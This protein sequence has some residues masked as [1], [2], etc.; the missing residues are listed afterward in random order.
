[1]PKAA[2]KIA[3]NL[4]LLKPQSSP[5]KL[6]VKV[7]RWL[8]STGRFIFVAVEALVLMA[9]IFRFKLDADLATRKEAIEE[10]I[11]YIESL[12]PFEI[13]IRQTQLKLETLDAFNQNL[14][15]YSLILKRL[16][17]QLPL[18]VKVISISLEKAV[19]KVTVQINASAQT[20]SDLSTFVTSMK[21]DQYFSEINL[22]SV[23]LEQGVIRFTIS[24]K[25]HTT[26]GVRKL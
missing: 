12:H 10:Q 17:E 4:D 24:T 9:F 21:Q 3:I 5:Q 1:M 13:L 15:D 14:A 22:A 19:G 18:G 2:S 25:V 8:L 20:N 7:M 23:G 11:P 26:S 6:P 16:S